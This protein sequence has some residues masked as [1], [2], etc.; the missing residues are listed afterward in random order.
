MK[1]I[2]ILLGFSLIFF[3]VSR[4]IGDVEAF[5]KLEKGNQGAQDSRAWENGRHSVWFNRGCGCLLFLA[6]IFIILVRQGLRHPI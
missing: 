3:L 6:V 5:N 1:L 4:Y 2:V